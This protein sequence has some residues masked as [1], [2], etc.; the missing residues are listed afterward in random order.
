MSWLHRLRPRREHNAW[1]GLCAICRGWGTGRVCAACLAR[2]A[3]ALPRCLQCGLQVPP[4]VARCGACLTDPPPFAST[5]AAVDYAHPWD[6]LVTQFKFHQALDLAGAFAARM[7]EAWN[8][9]ARARPD[10]LLPVPLSDAR[11]RERGYNQAWEL[12]RRLGRA[13]GGEVDARLLLRVKDT[14]HQLALPPAQRAANVRHA[15]AI[16]PARRAALQ[17]RRI[18]VVDDV[19]T[20]GATAAEIART[21]RR[22]G[23]A[24]VGFWVLARTPRPA[25]D[26]DAG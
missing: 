10:L 21:L 9:T 19:M 2:F 6:R 1:P 23:A 25:H 26:E 4:G 22:A 5:V 11:L 13:L 16:E 15:F 20:T 8:A 14:P 17:G 24:E 18:T 7:H 12:T 3:P